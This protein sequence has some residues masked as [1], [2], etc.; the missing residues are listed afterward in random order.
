MAK[1]NRKS[2]E[3]HETANRQKGAPK[4]KA[5]PNPKKTE[6]PRTRLVVDT[7]R[8][9]RDGHEFH[10]AWVARKCLGVGAH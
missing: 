1:S 10:E 6:R 4:S 9:S 8:A 3:T 2:T 5:S 7:V